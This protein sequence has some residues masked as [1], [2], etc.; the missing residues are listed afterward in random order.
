MSAGDC[1]LP[2]TD[3]AARSDFDWLRLSLPNYC[4]ALA[5]DFRSSGLKLILATAL[6]GD[7]RSSGRKLILAAALA[8]DFRSSGRKLILATAPPVLMQIL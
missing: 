2:D 3:S 6:A 8:G 1:S 7:F 4:T 5:G